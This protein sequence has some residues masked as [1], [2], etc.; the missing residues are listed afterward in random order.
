M[1]HLLCDIAGQVSMCWE[2]KPTGVFDATGVMKIVEANVH[3]FPKHLEIRDH[4]TCMPVLTIPITNNVMTRSVGYTDGMIIMYC[5]ET[6]AT[7]S[8]LFRWA[9]EWHRKVHQ[10]IVDHW[11]ELTDGQVIDFRVVRGETD[12]P[13]ESQY[14]HSVPFGLG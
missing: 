10:Y 5:L 4:Q 14:H 12:V 11:K 1:K 6:G 7:E 2:P 13:C 8:Q 9:S 3:K